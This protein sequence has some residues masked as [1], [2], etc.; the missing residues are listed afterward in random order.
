MKYKIT[1]YL[2]LIVLIGFGALATAS[3]QPRTSNPETED[4]ATAVMTLS[5]GQTL[6]ISV[7]NPL[8]PALPGA[9]GRKFKM[10]VAPLVL[11][12]DGRV[13]AR[14]DEIT[15]EPGEFQSFD[16]KRTDLPGETGMDGL[17]L[18]IEV[19]RRFPGFFGTVRVASGDV[20][21]VVELIDDLTGRTEAVASLRRVFTTRS[22][23]E[24]LQMRPAL[25]G[26]SDG[27][28]LRV[29]VTHMKGDE[30]NQLLHARIRL[31]DS[32]GNLIAESSELVIPPGEFRSY[33]F[34]RNALPLT[35][36]PGTGR[37]Q[38]AANIFLKFDPGKIDSV[39][40]TLELVDNSTGRTTALL[41]PAIQRIR[42]INNC[43]SC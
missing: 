18:R 22:S 8:P 16:F 25:F 32:N 11:A 3:A 17:P 30:G 9:D 21:G 43:S 34:P 12:A 23:N 42:N 7:L 20:N 13:I 1:D 27:Q 5:P 36:E 41:L 24:Q 28:T 29:H 33:D 14:R 4:I 31:Q 6:R 15:L 39:N 10:L 38:M 35:G 40:A 37:V 2:L 26:L 19:R